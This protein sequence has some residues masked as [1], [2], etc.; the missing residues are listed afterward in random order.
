MT[1]QAREGRGAWE[2][3]YHVPL[4]QCYPNSR[5]TQAS[6]RVHLH[7]LEYVDLGRI[8]CFPGNS[9][10]RKGG[11]YERPAKPDEQRC[12]ICVERAERYG[13]AWPSPERAQ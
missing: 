7:A 4:N 2:V 12:P 3:R 8:K 10:C 9:L 13:V 5:G 1:P 11:L 6:G